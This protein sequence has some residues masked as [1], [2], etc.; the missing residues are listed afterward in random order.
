V[1]AVEALPAPAAQLRQTRAVAAGGVVLSDPMVG[2]DAAALED[3]IPVAVAQAPS[4]PTGPAQR[5]LRE[6]WC[7]VR[8]APTTDQP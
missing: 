2:A 6:A 3:G 5:G 7:P 4:L 1:S 8:A